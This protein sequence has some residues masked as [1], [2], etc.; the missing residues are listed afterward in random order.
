MWNPLA[1]VTMATAAADAG[2]RSGVRVLVLGG[3]GRVAFV[4]YPCGH[5]HKKY[6]I[7]SRIQRQERRNVR[8]RVPPPPPTTTKMPTRGQDYHRWRRNVWQRRRTTDHC[9]GQGIQMCSRM[10][11]GTSDG[12]RRGVCGRQRTPRGGRQWTHRRQRG[13]PHSLGR[14]LASQTMTI[15]RMIEKK[16]EGGG[17]VG[18]FHAQHYFTISKKL[19]GCAVFYA[20]YF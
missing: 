19:I 6:I 16:R 14:P 2:G 7:I 12:G 4:W 15:L 3:R 11:I 13:R 1:G 10:P 18:G 5:A 20:H 17:G 9:W 8:R